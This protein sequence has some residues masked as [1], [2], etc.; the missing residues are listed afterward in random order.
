MA[1]NKTHAP[2]AQKSVLGMLIDDHREVQTLFKEFKSVKDDAKKNQIVQH[3][4]MALTA[5]AEIEEK[6]FYPFLRK[7]DPDTFGDMLDEG[8]VEHGSAK[9][10]I[11]LLKKMK[12]G[13][14]LYD[15]R[16]TVLGEFTNHHITEEEDEMFSKVV[17]KDIDLRELEAPML[18]T[19]KQSM[20]A[21]KANKK[22]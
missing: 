9:D 16:F 12:P 18:E 10:L 6:H 7:A 13:D 8:K 19:K 21:Q 11:A 4:C 3:A 14:D 15:A 2:A 22:S 20:A 17:S 1:M 5:H